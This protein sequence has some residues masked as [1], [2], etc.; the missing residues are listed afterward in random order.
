MKYI[1]IFMLFC[2]ILFSPRVEAEIVDWTLV[3]IDNQAV[4]YGEFIKTYRELKVNLQKTGDP[5]M[6]SI[7]ATNVFDLLINNKILN[8]EANKKEIDVNEQDV[9]QRIESIKKMNSWNDEL[10]KQVL[11]QQGLTEKELRKTFRE[12]IRNE[13][14]QD[15]EIRHKVKAP[16]DDEMRK[17][18]NDNKAQMKT[19]EKYL[20]SHILFAQPPENSSLSEQL[21]VKKKLEAVYKQVAS[22]GDFAAAARQYS[23]D[24][25]SAA[26][27]G[28]LG[29]VERGAM[30]P[31]FEEQLFKLKK[32]QV[33]QPFPSRYGVHI[34]K[35][36]DVK[37]P[38]PVSFEDAKMKIKPVL[39]QQSLQTEFMNWVREKRKVYGI[40][41]TFKDGTSWL[42]T[43]GL[44]KELST[45][46][47]MT[48][49]LFYKMIS[50][51]LID[52]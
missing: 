7:D 13:K 30:V 34:I 1:S 33:S 50:K 3:T 47:T 45:G 2:S 51:K 4:P 42:Y 23:S 48:Q 35:V 26:N 46:K 44:W 16:T 27:G 12:Q 20:A 19:P 18:Y 36:F 22:G 11:K 17:F 8:L 31:E 37:K 5:N 25:V 39:M 15:L 9:D 29:W 32:G 40:S 38:E 21:A 24:E 52:G 41:L 43:N 49:N 28:S 10:F 6:K 14:L